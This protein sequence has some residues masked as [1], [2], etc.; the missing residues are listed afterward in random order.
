MAKLK[1]RWVAPI[2]HADDPADKPGK[3]A[4]GPMAW[5]SNAGKC[6]FESSFQAPDGGDTPPPPLVLIGHAA[7][8]PPH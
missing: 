1:P 7:S 5:A 6:T 3:P 8:L 2:L 4:A